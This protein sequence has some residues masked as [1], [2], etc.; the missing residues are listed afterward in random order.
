MKYIYRNEAG[1]PINIGGYQFATGAELS[2]DIIIERFK[3]AVSN[4]F[5]ILKEAGADDAPGL[6][7]LPESG[8]GDEELRKAAEEAVKAEEKRAAAEIEAAL[9]AEKNR[10]A[11]EA[12]IAEEARLA[13][14]AR[15]AEEARLAEE[16][17]IAE[18]AENAESE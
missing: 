2:S 15:A 14:E 13:E 10:L 8:T 1:R 9:A 3:E 4:E 6:S 16:A 11:E 7:S 5:L 18:E 12:R 17:H